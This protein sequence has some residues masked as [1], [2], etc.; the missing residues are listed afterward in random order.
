MVTGSVRIWVGVGTLCALINWGGAGHPACADIVVY[1]LPG[2]NLRI[3]LEG[4]ATVNTGGTVS[5]RHKRGTLH[6][7]TRDVQIIKTPSKY[8]R[9]NI[10]AQK[11]RSGGDVDSMLELSKW[12]ISN[13]M[14]KE[15]D[16]ALSSAWKADSS[17]KRVQTLGML[18]KYRRGTVPSTPSAEQ[19][20]AKFLNMKGMKVARSRHYILMHDTSD[21]INPI[22]RKTAAQHRLDLLEKVY[23]SFYMKFALDGYPLAIPRQP[24]RVVLF[25]EQANYLVFVARLSPELKNTAGFYSPKDNIAIFYRQK[26]DEALEGL[27]Q[28]SQSLKTLRDQ[29]KRT[30]VAGAGEIIRFAKT[31]ELLID[32]V[33]ENQEIEVVTHE[34]THQLAANSKLMPRA[35]F[36][37]R[38]AHEGLASYFES[39]KDASW[40]GI[41]AVNEQ[42][43]MWYRLLAA[44]TEHSNIKFI[45]TDRIFDYAQSNGAQL[46][47]YGQSW[48]LTHFLMDQHMPELMKFYR[49]MGKQPEDQARTEQWREDTYASFQEIF[50]N[51][52]TLEAQWRAYMRSLK[53]DTAKLREQL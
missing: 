36:N 49:L 47:A 34:A 2:T 14:L 44:D 33:G 37:M 38:W 22:T 6:F 32:I 26:S 39:P 16:A 40:A 35:T 45:V 18:T 7:S 10:Q 12:C 42:R 51:T 9:Y 30:R 50:G 28:L 31:L 46:A 29:V 52:Q 21:E 20:M 27:Q 15:A 13:G 41:G 17:D 11:A 5:Y 4:K 25:D 1:T 3:P 24:M 19:E 43:L 23:D 48:A 8:A 53:T